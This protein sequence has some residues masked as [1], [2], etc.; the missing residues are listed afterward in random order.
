MRKMTVAI[1][2]SYLLGILSYSYVQEYGAAFFVIGVFLLAAGIKAILS[3]KCFTPLGIMSACVALGL[4]GNFWFSDLPQKSFYPLIDQPITL[5]ARISDV[6]EFDG[7]KVTYRAQML[8]AK[9]ADGAVSKLNGSVLI[10]SYGQP[11]SY[12]AQFYDVVEFKTKLTLPRE[13]MNEGNFDYAT[14]LKGKNIFVTAETKEPVIANLGRQSGSFSLLTPVYTFKAEALRLIDKYLA[15]EEKE[16][17]KALLLG[18]KTNLSEETETDFRRAGLSHVLAIS[19]LHLNIL[20][21]YLSALTALIP[22]KSRRI[23]APVLNILMALFMIFVTGGSASVSRAAIMLIFANLANLLFRERDHLHALLLSGLLMLVINPA[24]AYSISF[25]LS[26]LSTLGIVLFAGRLSHFLLRFVRVRYLS[27]SIAITLCAQLFTLPVIAYVFNEISTL[28]ILSNLLVVPFLPLLTISAILFLAAA[29]LLPFAANW[30]AG[31]VFIITRAVLFLVH[32][33]SNI[34]FSLVTVGGK[35]FVIWFA[36]IALIVVFACIL[37]KTR[38]TAERIAACCAMLVAVCCALVFQGIGSPGLE[39]TFLNVGQGDAALIRTPKGQTVLIDGGGSSSP[40]SDTGKYI[41]QPYLLRQ[42]ITSLDYAVVSHFHDDHTEGIISLLKTFDIGSLIVP[43]CETPDNDVRDDV[44]STAVS[45]HVPIYYFSTGSRVHLDSGVKL[46]TYSPQSSLFYDDNNA[47]LVL[48][49]TYG[50]SDILFTGDI[51]AETE[52]A[53]A[54]V[55]P[56]TDVL[57]T[58]H[59]GSN[60]SSTAPLLDTVR[61]QIAVISVGEDNKYGHPSPETIDAFQRRGIRFFR[62]D[63]SGTITLKATAD[64]TIRIQTRKEATAS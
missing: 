18:V 60:T 62:T 59:H 19:G 31:F 29:F 34:P 1:L 47:S 32:M 15:G 63:Q 2:L 64:G 24:N 42:G 44:L 53:L 55:L 36:A 8:S 21:L 11:A 27:D 54:E 38:Q 23:A 43:N 16:L 5:T 12:G 51:E 50:E 57:K 58:P 35:R 17:I 49:L 46:E 37:V 6:P 9:T 45:Q 52:S 4:L 22:R 10:Y 30:F 39:V 61:P 56:Q 14:Y 3:K 33:L 13:E 48:R 20:L 40:S 28:A 7:E 25:Q 41:I 26:F